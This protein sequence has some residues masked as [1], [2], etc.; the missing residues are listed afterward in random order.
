LTKS[1]CLR[2]PKASGQEAIEVA[3]QLGLHNKSFKIEQ[4]ADYLYIPLSR[5]SNCEEEKTLK[6]TLRNPKVC[7]HDFSTPVLRPKNSMELLSEELPSHLVASIP[8]SADFVGDIAV[9]EIPIGLSAYKRKIGEAVLV[10]NKRV[11]TVLAKA[12]AISGVYR[13]RK[14][15]VIAGEPKTDTVYSEYGCI[16]YIDLSKAYFSPRLSS[17]HAR[18]SKLVKE[19]ETIVDMFAGVGPFAIQIAKQHKK[20]HV[21]AVDVNPDATELL[22]KNAAANR[23]LAKVIPILGDVRK[24]VHERLAGVADRVIMNLPEKAIEYVNVACEALKPTGGIMHY[25]AFSKASEPTAATEDGLIEVV[26]KAHRKVDKIISSR[27]VRA[28]APYKWQVVVDAR[29]R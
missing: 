5:R 29:I 8:R 16:F 2:I 14:F 23:V 27:T 26:E 11:R 22:N 9:V 28:T 17:E 21:Y 20:V 25:Y 13:T 1:P 4:N 24:V 3:R 7:I 6:K 15:E 12:S 19:G 10:A 18:I